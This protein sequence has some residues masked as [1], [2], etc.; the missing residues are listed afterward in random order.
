MTVDERHAVRRA[1]FEIRQL[2]SVAQLDGGF[3]WRRCPDGQHVS[4]L[5]FLAHA[6]PGG[7]C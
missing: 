3:H 5:P 4:L 2:P 1:N 6:G 7:R